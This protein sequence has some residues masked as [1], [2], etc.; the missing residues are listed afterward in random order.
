[1]GSMATA[2]ALSEVCGVQVAPLSPDLKR[3]MLVAA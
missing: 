3:P 1:M 2:R